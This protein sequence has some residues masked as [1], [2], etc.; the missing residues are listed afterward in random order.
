MPE[1]AEVEYYRKQWLP[2]LGQ[3][4][5]RVQLHPGKRIY[6]GSDTA[7]L[8]RGLKG[9]T[10][11]RAETH[12]KQMVFV[13]G[14]RHW[15]GV[16]LGMTGKT[17][18]QDAAYT[19]S[20]HDH[21]V[22]EM[23]SGLKLVFTDPRLFGRIR[24][25]KTSSPPDWWSGLPPEVLSDAFT[26]EHMEQFLLRR[27][28]SPIKAVLLMQEAFPGIGNWMADEI[29]WRARIHP[30]M[31]AGQLSVGQCK[32][33]YRRLREVCRDA[34]RVIGT[35]W[36]RPPDSWLFNHRWK[37]GGSC[38]KTGVPLRREP[39]GGRTTCWSPEWQGNSYRIEKSKS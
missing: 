9:Q 17:S 16:H 34:L 20:K 33:L 10:L 22:L 13:F 19:Q 39:I 8:L 31:P 15:L 27:A 11:K 32:A 12:G 18:T 26:R 4:V 21:L 23:K 2:G 3:E 7:A 1:L 37:D 38:P 5:A 28:K 24:Y 6:R 35:D 36:G 29:L 14:D 30:A 25:S